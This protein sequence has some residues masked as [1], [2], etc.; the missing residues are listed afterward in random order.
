MERVREAR[1]ADDV[2]CGMII[3][4]ASMAGP[5]VSR[6]PH[7]RELFADTSPLAPEGYRRLVSMDDA[8]VVVGFTDFDPE[9][10]HIRYLFVDPAHQGR[11]LGSALIEAAEAL[12]AARPLT[13]NC[14]A[15]ND[16]ALAW[17]LDHGFENHG[18]GF[19]EF[20]GRRVVEIHLRRAES[21]TGG[22]LGWASARPSLIVTGTRVNS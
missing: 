18:G 20:R 2:A 3:S 4:R 19:A 21:D 14:F 13:L 17:Y 6:L 11:G 8:D 12:A 16:V 7:A 9:R 1:R 10:P 22:V 15:A 5:L